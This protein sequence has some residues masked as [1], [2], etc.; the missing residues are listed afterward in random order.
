MALIP[1]LSSVFLLDDGWPDRNAYAVAG[2]RWQ[3]V[4]VIKIHIYKKNCY[5]YLIMPK[6]AIYIG[7]NNKSNNY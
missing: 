2:L 4:S 7:N 6:C 5:Y 3:P 1:S